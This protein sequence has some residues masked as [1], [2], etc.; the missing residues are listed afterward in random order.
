MLEKPKDDPPDCAGENRIRRLEQE[1]DNF[2]REFADFSRDYTRRHDELA[3][4]MIGQSD[5]V[6]GLVF[7]S[8]LAIVSLL[9]GIIGWMVS[10]QIFRP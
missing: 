4:R 5:I 3:E 1:F 7:R 6:R 10:H 8:A 2:R 9:L